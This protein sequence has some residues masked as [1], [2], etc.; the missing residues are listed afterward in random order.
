LKPCNDKKEA[1]ELEVLQPPLPN[2]GSNPFKEPFNIKQKEEDQGEES[3]NKE[4]DEGRIYKVSSSVAATAASARYLE[5]YLEFGEEEK[6][7]VSN[8]ESSMLVEASEV[9]LLALESAW[10]S[11]STSTSTLIPLPINDSLSSNGQMDINNFPAKFAKPQS[12]QVS[13]ESLEMEPAVISSV[14]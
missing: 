3:E 2:D 10:V 7:T 13:F 8:K 9:L 1:E 4:K 5:I 11:T 12:P 14:L 6:H